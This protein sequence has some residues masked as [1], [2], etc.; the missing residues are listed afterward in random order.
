MACEEEWG[1]GPG[2]YAYELCQDCFINRVDKNVEHEHDLDAY[3]V[4]F[5]VKEAPLQNF[6]DDVTAQKIKTAHRK[7]RKFVTEIE[8]KDKVKIF[9]DEFPV[10]EDD[11]KHVLKDEESQLTLTL[12]TVGENCVQMWAA[13]ATGDLMDIKDG[14]TVMDSKSQ[15][16]AKIPYLSEKIK[17]RKEDIWELRLKMRN[18]SQIAMIAPENMSG[19]GAMTH[20]GTQP[21]AMLPLAEPSTV[22]GP[23]PHCVLVGINAGLAYAV[24]YR[25]LE[26]SIH[27]ALSLLHYASTQEH[28]A[29]LCNG[30]I[31]PWEVAMDL[32]VAGLAVTLYDAGVKTFSPKGKP[33][34]CYGTKEHAACPLVKQKEDLE[35][36]LTGSGGI[37]VTHNKLFVGMEA[38]SVILLTGDVATDSEVRSGLLRA[39]TRLVLICDKQGNARPS[40]KKE[41]EKKFEVHEP[42]IANEFSDRQKATDIRVQHLCPS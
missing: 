12:R 25:S 39:V 33:K 11:L 7:L 9:L 5:E 41:L 38:P 31:C 23:Q 6:T 28:L 30:R 10:S 35:M 40:V 1:E 14:G 27:Y 32:R 2:E 26:R 13:L 20:D 21:K 15:N 34:E 42:K 36:W 8:N 37:L 18:T 17:L 29:I 3:M 22:P 19:F 16:L 24:Y 4:M